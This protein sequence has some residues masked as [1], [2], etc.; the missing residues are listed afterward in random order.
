[1]K[2]SDSYDYF[3]T[4]NVNKRDKMSKNIN[5]VKTC[6]IFYLIFSEYEVRFVVSA[7]TTAVLSYNS[8]RFRIARHFP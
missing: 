2:P 7:I 8:E 5:K 3:C 4:D 1:M 6:F